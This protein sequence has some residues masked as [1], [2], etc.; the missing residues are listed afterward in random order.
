MKSGLEPNKE[1]VHMESKKEK[2]V[3]IHILKKGLSRFTSDSFQII[4]PPL[5]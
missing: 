3:L 4:V 2:E 1:E 5:S